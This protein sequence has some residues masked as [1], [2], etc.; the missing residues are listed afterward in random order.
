MIWGSSL[1]QRPIPDYL[2]RRFRQ[3]RR[4]T[5]AGKTVIWWLSGICTTEDEKRSMMLTV[6]NGH[7][8]MFW[9]AQ[10]VRYNGSK[11]LHHALYTH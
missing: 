7:R 8:Q 4:A 6:D 9:A 10:V 2:V 1:G 3:R 11:K 5:L